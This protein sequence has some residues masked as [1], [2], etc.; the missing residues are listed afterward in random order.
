MALRISLHDSHAWEKQD[1]RDGVHDDEHMRCP[2]RVTSDHEEEAS[3]GVAVEVCVRDGA[4]RE[5]GEEQHDSPWPESAETGGIR[6]GGAIGGGCH[7]T[8]TRLFTEKGRH[9][10]YGNQ[11]GSL[12][13]GMYLLDCFHR[14]R[15]IREA[16]LTLRQI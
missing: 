14:I 10:T 5:E 15:T 16:D 9:A 4:E 3:G 7:P 2:P 11:A 8:I 6:L 12:T 13:P 1:D